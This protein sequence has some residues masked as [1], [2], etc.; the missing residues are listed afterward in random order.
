MWG[1]LLF[2]MALNTVFGA[3]L[4]FIEV[5]IL[6]LHI[7]GFFAVMLP[8]VWLAR[9]NDSSSVFKTFFNAGGW[10]TQTLSFFVGLR[11]N[12]VPFLGTYCLSHVGVPD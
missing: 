4:P 7:Y 5:I 9:H 1:V 6:V 12:A 2:C 8:L 3:I 10:Q 11:G